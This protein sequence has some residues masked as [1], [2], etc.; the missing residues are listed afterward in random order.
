LHYDANKDATADITKGSSGHYL[1]AST[2]FDFYA[3]QG[4]VKIFS[5]NKRPKLGHSCNAHAM[6]VLA[7]CLLPACHSNWIAS[8]HK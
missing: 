1:M 8:T 4:A 5:A 2:D 7:I 6:S 3:V